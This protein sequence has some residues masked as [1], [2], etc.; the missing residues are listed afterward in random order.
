MIYLWH[1]TNNGMYEMGDQTE[2]IIMESSYQVTL[3][4]EFEANEVKC[5]E[6]ILLNLNRASSELN[7]SLAMV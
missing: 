1:N 7:P 4:H 3:I 2:M 5:A 6:K